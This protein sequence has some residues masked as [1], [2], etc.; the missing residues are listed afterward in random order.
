MKSIY[1]FVL[2]GIAFSILSVLLVALS[3]HE[4]GVSSQG[5]PLTSTQST[6]LQSRSSTVTTE[7]HT[8][9][10]SGLSLANSSLE[11][12]LN[13]REGIRSGRIRTT[14][15]SALTRAKLEKLRFES[16]RG[17]LVAAVELEASVANCLATV[18]SSE[19]EL[20]HGVSKQAPG[21]CWPAFGDDIKSERDLEEL[22]LELVGKFVA[23]GIP[24]SVI[25]Y[26]ILAKKYVQDYQRSENLSA[27]STDI[28]SLA[29]RYLVDAASKRD[30]DAAVLLSQ[31][32]S[33]GWFGIKDPSLSAKYA[34]LANKL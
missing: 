12:A 22:R 29:T 26:S 23:A 13:L 19:G 15:A 4:L 6:G 9:G 25:D 20:R 33:A 8:E 27:V 2:V 5:H 17:D 10:L 1:R 3:R 14:V 31:A 32:Y 30:K 28:R 21:P 7:S 16:D 24:N 34:D 11:L 18:Y